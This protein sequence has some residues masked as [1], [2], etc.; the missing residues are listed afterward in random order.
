MGVDLWFLVSSS[1]PNPPEEWWLDDALG[2]E[3][4]WDIDTIE[5]ERRT[6]II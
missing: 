1:I 2:K 5:A 3:M 4:G 6:L